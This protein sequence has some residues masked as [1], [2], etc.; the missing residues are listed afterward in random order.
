M[1]QAYNTIISCE[2]CHRGIHK[3]HLSEISFFKKSGIILELMVY[4]HKKYS[5]SLKFTILTDSIR[6]SGEHNYYSRKVYD[7]L[8]E[9]KRFAQVYAQM[10][11]YVAGSFTFKYICVRVTLCLATVLNCYKFFRIL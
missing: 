6:P 7:L 9:S 8:F 1:H 10:I 3:H 4:D 11:V 2:C 5:P